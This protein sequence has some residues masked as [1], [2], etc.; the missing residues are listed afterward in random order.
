MVQGTPSLQD[1][2]AFLCVVPSLVLWVPFQANGAS[3]RYVL[4]LWYRGI[5]HDFSDQ[6]RVAWL[7]V[8]GRWI[9]Y[10]FV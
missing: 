6:L 2:D 1:L 4:V 9:L 7:P 5:D 3:F 10:A 8:S